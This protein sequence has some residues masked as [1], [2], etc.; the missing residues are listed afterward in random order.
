MGLETFRINASLQRTILPGQL[1]KILEV[2]TVDNH[3]VR[4]SQVK[5]DLKD[6]SRRC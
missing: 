5:L 4:R 1:T 3:S 6:R 2:G